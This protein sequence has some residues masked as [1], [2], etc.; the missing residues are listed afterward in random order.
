MMA[1]AGVTLEKN[2]KV[3]QSKADP[4]REKKVSSS[5]QSIETNTHNA[6]TSAQPSVIGAAAAS[7]VTK[8]PDLP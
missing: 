1:E 4:R 2:P 6:R 8:T 7:G 5:T 3:G